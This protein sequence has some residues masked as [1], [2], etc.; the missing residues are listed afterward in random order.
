M[1]PGSPVRPLPLVSYENLLTMPL[2]PIPWLVEPLIA[3][4]DRVIVYGAWGSYKSWVLA[5]LAL[6]L[7]AGRTWL[8]KFPIATGTNRVLYVDEEMSLRLFTRRLKRLA[9]GMSLT[10]ESLPVQV[11]SRYGMR[12]EGVWVDDLLHQLKECDF[13]PDVV[14]I[15]TF[16]RVF[17]GDEISAKDVAAFW[18]AL[19]PLSKAGK[20]II[21]SHH[22]RK[23][24]QNGKGPI[25]DRFSGSTDILAGAD[26]ALALERKAKDAFIIEHVKCREAEETDA[27]AVS[28][29]EEHAEGPVHLRF[30]GTPADLKAEGAR[31]SKPNSLFDHSCGLLQ[32]TRPAQL[33]CLPASRH[34]ESRQPPESE[35]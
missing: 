21:I 12:I 1:S 3:T 34:V 14:I 32:T 26:S 18:Q 28:F 23:P 29:F 15:E 4:G 19:S 22:M 30:E 31:H 16:R 8:E 7:A 6:H 2:E 13:D 33:N 20:T 11:L 35:P 27:F 17:R 5:S 9:L 10:T 25:R 24:G